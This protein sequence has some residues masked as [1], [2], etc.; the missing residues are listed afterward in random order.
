VKH[1][2]QNHILYVHVDDP[3]VTM[4]VNTPEEYATLRVPQT[5]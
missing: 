3:H 5:K 2:Q 4:N 1:Q